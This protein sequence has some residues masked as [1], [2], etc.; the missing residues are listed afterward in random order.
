MHDQKENLA[1]SYSPGSTLYFTQFLKN[2]NWV[3]TDVDYLWT[4]F[5]AKVA[6]FDLGRG[7]LYRRELGLLLKGEEIVRVMRLG[8]FW[9][10]SSLLPC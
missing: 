8:A 10:L 4:R 1:R 9:I 5:I 2:P 3:L 6:E 7:Y